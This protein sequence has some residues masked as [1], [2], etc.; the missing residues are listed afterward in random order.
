MEL[1]PQ[2][3]AYIWRGQGNNCNSYLLTSALADGR[4][5]LVDPGQV[6][7]PQT[8]EPGLERLFSEIAR[9]GLDPTSIGLIL[10][11][12]CHPDHVEAAGAIREQ[13]GA[14]VA[15]HRTESEVVARFGIDVDLLLEEGDLKLGHH[16]P[17][18]INVLHTP[19]HSPGHVAFYWKKEKVLIAGDLVFFR[20]T[21]RSDL[22]GGSAEQLRQS[23]ARVA[24]LD[25]EFLLCG[26]P[27]GHPGVIV[28]KAEVTEN[29]AFLDIG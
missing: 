11:T 29:F 14:L 3:Y 13:T 22:P 1:L 24:K 2:L 6:Q 25:T 4:H 9:D 10:L 21:G 27:Y 17:I 26:H 20:S 12:H 8:R 7:V 16:R 19:G 23:I 5:V 18:T 15:I 28:G